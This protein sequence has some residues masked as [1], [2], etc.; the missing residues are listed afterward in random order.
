[1]VSVTGVNR[2]KIPGSFAVHLMKD[3]KQIASRFVFQPDEVD[4]C[5][6]C[7]KNPIAHFD[8]D[9]PL[10]EVTG[11]KLSVQVEPVNKAVVGARFPSKLMG[12]PT[13]E[14]SHPVTDD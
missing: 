12:N 8:F 13:I 7:V 3:G 10:A 1:M 14:R 11:G 2:V 4:K 5:E 6:T 9:L